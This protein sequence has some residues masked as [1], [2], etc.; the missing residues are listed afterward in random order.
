MEEL[1]V[2]KGKRLDAPGPACQPGE[3]VPAVQSA[4]KY[5]YYYYYYLLLLLYNSPTIVT[6][7]VVTWRIHKEEP[8]PTAQKKAQI[9]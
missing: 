7:L 1:I 2:E 4:K 9:K 5:Y 8:G 6:D 3:N